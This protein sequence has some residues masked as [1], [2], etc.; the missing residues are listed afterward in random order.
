M[1]PQ[2][3]TVDCKC[4]HILMGRRIPMQLVLPLYDTR[5]KFLSNDTWVGAASQSVLPSNYL[6][7]QRH[8]IDIGPLLVVSHSYGSYVPLSMSYA[9]CCLPKFPIDR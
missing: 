7:I 4:C 9:S 8:V 2:H 3:C 6:L 1:E 5:F